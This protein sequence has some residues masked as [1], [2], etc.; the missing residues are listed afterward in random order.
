LSRTSDAGYLITAP[1]FDGREMRLSLRRVPAVRTLAKHPAL[2]ALAAT[3]IG[4]QAMPFRATLFD[5]SPVVAMRPL[6]VHASS[7]AESDQARRVLHIEYATSVHFGA[8]VE[9]VVG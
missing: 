5:K 6:V 4:E 9:L 1:L 8:G 3:F 2:I 7:K